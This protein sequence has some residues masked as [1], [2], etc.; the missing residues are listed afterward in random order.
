MAT[1]VLE[2]LPSVRYKD[3]LNRTDRAIIYRE[4]PRMAKFFTLVVGLSLVA[5]MS[6]AAGCQ[7]DADISAQAPLPPPNFNPPTIQQQPPVVYQPV[8]TAPRPTPAP[9]AVRPVAPAP[10]RTF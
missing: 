8:Q 2:I 1:R 7:S 10:H 9:V 6:F 4:E 3:M 5:L